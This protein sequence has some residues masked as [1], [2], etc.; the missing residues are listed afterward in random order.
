MSDDHIAMRLGQAA[1]TQFAGDVT[2]GDAVEAITHHALI[3]QGTRQ[4]EAPR[5]GILAGMEGGIEGGRLRQPRTQPRDGADQAQVL[6]LVQRRQ[7]GQRLQLILD[8]G[9]QQHRFG[10]VQ[11]AVDDAMTDG[12]QGTLIMTDFELVQDPLQHLLHGGGRIGI[13]G[14]G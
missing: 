9:I 11:A 5:Q 3:M 2:V 8:A 7:R 12:I 14:D 1:P 6:R 4:C 10:Q 13:D